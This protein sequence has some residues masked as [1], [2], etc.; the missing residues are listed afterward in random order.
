M[1]KPLLKKGEF[2]FSERIT[3]QGYD[4]SSWKNSCWQDL[5]EMG[6]AEISEA[7]ELAHGTSQLVFCGQATD[8]RE[9]F[10]TERQQ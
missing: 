5:G 8:V 10:G 4:S 9:G 2:I 3:G 7:K 1:G 6:K